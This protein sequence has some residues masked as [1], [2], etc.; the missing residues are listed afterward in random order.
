MSFDDKKY[1]ID[2]EP[3]SAMD[4]INRAKEL[5]ASYGRDGL[6]MTSTAA[7]VLRNNGHKVE[8]NPS[9]AQ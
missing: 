2:N 3:A 4:I 1:L 7:T 5:D 6:S 9:F 8:E